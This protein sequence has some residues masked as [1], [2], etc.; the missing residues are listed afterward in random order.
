MPFSENREKGSGKCEVKVSA[1]ARTS[2]EVAEGQVAEVA[3]SGSLSA[4]RL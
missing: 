2:V 1:H 4:P 3:V